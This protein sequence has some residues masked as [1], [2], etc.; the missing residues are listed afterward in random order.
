MAS[1]Q[2]HGL[3]IK[4]RKSMITPNFTNKG[5]QIILISLS[6]LIRMS[7]MQSKSL[8]FDFKPVSIW[9]PYRAKS[10]QV[11][12]PRWS[13]GQNFSLLNNAISERVILL[14]VYSLLAPTSK[15]FWGR[16]LKKRVTFC[17]PLNFLN[18]Q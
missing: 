8:G 2:C 1:R 16:L 18:R 4:I 3:S 17:V 15:L 12:L 9:H 11:H 13:R 10:L 5:F 6:V 7:S 14:F